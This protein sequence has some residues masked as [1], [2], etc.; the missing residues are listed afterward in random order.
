MRFRWISLLATVGIFAALVPIALARPE[1]DE[2]DRKEARAIGLAPPESPLERAREE[3]GAG[4][5]SRGR[6]D[7]PAGDLRVS[8]TQ[9]L[10]AR[11]GQRIR[12]TVTLDRR[13]PGATLH[14]TLP[15]RWT[16][17][18]PGRVPAIRGTVL[19]SRA[20]GRA[21]LR[22]SGRDLA[23]AFDDA[24][25]G[26]SA[27]F[28]VID[29]GIPAG[30]W[31]LPFRWVDEATGRTT[32][33]RR[34]EIAFLAPSREG[35]TTTL[36][37]PGLAANSTN[38]G[39]EESETFI[40][41][42]P[43]NKDRIAVGINWPNASM[44]A[45][46][47]NDAGAT[48]T[49]RTLPQTIDAPGTA[50]PE[51]GSICC[52]PMMAADA[53]GNVWYGGLTFDPNGPVDGRIVVNRFAPGSTSL[54][55][56]TTGLPTRQSSQ[57]K[58]MM[59][60]DNG[61]TSPTF[62]RLYVVWN[63]AQGG[64]I[65]LVISQCDSRNNPANNASWCD[66][67]DNWT[68]PVSVTPST[69]SYI[70]GD[71]AVGPDGR[72][73]VTWWDYSS[74]NAIRGDVCNPTSQ[75]CAN[76]SG[77]GTPST[78][79]T[80]DLTGGV[81]IP[82]ACPIL[83]QPGGRAAPAPSVDVDHTGGPENGR[84][85]VTW[86]DLRPGS[87]T[88]RC[89][90]NL[91][92]ASTHLTWDSY[93][94]SAAGGA[95]PGGSSPSSLVGTRLITD[96]EG[97]G[98][99]NSDD[100]FAWLAVDQT[101][102]LAWADL[103]ST[104]DDSTRKKTNFYA[105]SVTPSGGSLALGPLTKVSA[106]QSDYS[107]A[108]C[109]TFGN[110]YG[111]Y[112]GIDATSGTAFPVWSDNSTGGG[113][114]EAEVFVGQPNTAQTPTPVTGAASN[115]G[116]QT[117][118][119]TG[120]VNPHLQ[121]T[122]WHVEYGTG[123]GY[124]NLTGNQT[125]SASGT[126]QPVPTTLSSLSPSTKYHYRLVATNASG[127]T[128][129]ADQT[130]TTTSGITQHQ[131]AVSKT[132]SGT[133]TSSPAGINCGA[134]CS[135]S[136]D[137]NT[138]VTL[139]A[140]PAAGWSFTSWGGACSGSGSCQVTMD[141]AKN[142]TATFTQ[143]SF[144]LDVSKN[145]TGTG[146]VTS[147]PAGIN[148]GG[149]CSQSYL[150]GTSV[151]LTA[152]PSAGSSFAGWSGSGCSGTGT[153]VVTMDQARSVTATFTQNPP[154]NFALTVQKG[155]SGTGTV[156]SGDGLINCGSDCGQTYSSGTQVSLSAAAGSGSR[157]GNWGGGCSG[158]GACNVT[159][160]Q[161]T[162]VTATFVAQHQLTVSTTGSGTVTSSPAGIS[163]PADCDQLYDQGNTV[164]LTPTPAAGWSFTGW[165]GACSGAGGCVVTMNAAQSVT[166]TFTENP[167]TGGGDGGTPSTPITSP[168][169][170]PPTLTSPIA[171]TFTLTLARLRPADAARRSL[172]LSARCRAACRLLGRAYLDG[173]TARRL[174]LVR[175]SRT[176]MVGSGSGVRTTAGTV[177]VVI[178]LTAR[179]RRAIRRAARVA[180]VLRVRGL[181]S[182]G[183]ASRTRYF[184]VT[185]RRSGRS[186]ILVSLAAAPS[187]V[188]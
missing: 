176:L 185:L 4:E 127:T 183:K 112:T 109:C 117:A 81:P 28:D 23:L 15:R 182:T 62:G 42:P 151:T 52:D 100:W 17:T 5:P 138:D 96:G 126:A 44:A 67:A 46:I 121:Q 181:D 120:T 95:L 54:Q 24:A 39:L 119:V 114:G 55:A 37:S 104:R 13:V 85:Y 57:D 58:P 130:F 43:G 88:T 175:T 80:L 134:D 65:N 7:L 75:N 11:P 73:Y 56:Q 99:A 1:G 125:L 150:S 139:T 173:T 105:R 41:T 84:V 159:M 3:S 133:V 163:C 168:P 83:A 60:V 128:N 26:A 61:P 45:W 18:L 178:V 6:F 147:S 164:S 40:A 166:A 38:D 22:R 157:F 116:S 179:T 64:G 142:V 76:A 59:T 123:L 86:G 31:R 169:L 48:W 187:G 106:G 101:T 136:Y 113:D 158:S 78:I 63:E 132:G 115:V 171:P 188:P 9:V 10:A 91:T 72:V 137:E 124:G 161:D 174:G 135:E 154:G 8:P 155:G 71:V 102:G 160:N 34:A 148:C 129:G 111:D 35:G 79:A 70:Y 20:G 27:S 74:A 66:N 162:T 90:G 53:R 92:P 97:G 107:G 29:N 68:T 2:A 36:A 186:P 172:P 144:A 103:Y 108:T 110:D 77:W 94:A 170:T 153:C 145:G 12:F 50:N 167:P 180:F 69:G 33:A 25:D 156:T 16:E 122:T 30:T 14:V 51:S 149:D 82:F 141:A 47:S 32:R 152:S 98:Q 21:R 118:D 19:R 143:Q 131:L 49:S 140:T 93:V 87:G 165:G 177:R 89:A 146:T 184:R